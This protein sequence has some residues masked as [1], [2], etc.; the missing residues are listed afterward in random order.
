MRIS[1]FRDFIRGE[2][3]KDIQIEFEGV[4]YEV[5]EMELTP[6]AVTGR[7]A[8]SQTVTLKTDRFEEIDESGTSGEDFV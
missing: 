8:R 7:S 3:V 2:N 4:L 1:K 5:K 6:S